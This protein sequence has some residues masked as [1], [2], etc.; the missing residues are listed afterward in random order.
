MAPHTVIVVH[1]TDKAEMRD[2]AIPYDVYAARVEKN[3]VFPGSIVFVH[4]DRRL[5]LPE[6]PPCSSRHSSSSASPSP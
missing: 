2:K 5:F 4:Y 6:N 1:R 3:R